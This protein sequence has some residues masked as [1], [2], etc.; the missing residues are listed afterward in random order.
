[1]NASR[2]AKLEAAFQ[3]ELAQLIVRE[4][5]D[6]RLE[7]AGLVTVTRVRMS[8]DGRHADV[9]VS[10]V[11]DEKIA[12]ARDGALVAFGR[13]AG[14]VR[15]EVARR[16]GLKR[17]PVL[18]FVHDQSAEL[19]ERIDRA[20]GASARGPAPPGRDASVIDRAVGASA[21]GENDEP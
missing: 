2:R 3:K 11:G 10:F 6:P 4:V 16:L 8:E 9:L 7:A 21:R 19:I 15:G 14:Y 5:K 1:M 20:E 12:G 17:A 13:M 18:R